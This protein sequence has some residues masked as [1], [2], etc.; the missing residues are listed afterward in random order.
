MRP[1]D[2]DFRCALNDPSWTI[3]ELDNLI[4]ICNEKKNQIWQVKHGKN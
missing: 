3:S 1:Q 2:V 4:A